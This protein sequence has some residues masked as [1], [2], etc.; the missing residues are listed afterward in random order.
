MSTKDWIEKDYY[1]V[2]GVSKDATPRRS[3][4]RTASWRETTTLIKT[5]ATPQPNCASRRSP[6]PTTCCRIRLSARST[7]RPAGCLEAAVSASRG[8]VV[9]RVTI[10]R[11]PLP[12]CRRRSRRHLRRPVQRQSHHAD[13]TVLHRR[14]PRR[15][16]DVEGEVTVDFVQAI[17]G[18]TVGMQ[19]VSD[20]A[21]E[22]CRHRRSGRDD[23]TCLPH[24]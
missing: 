23:S 19:M 4:R 18:V 20:T 8:A 12:Q 1:K 3:R 7:T 17:E 6:K 2:L 21:C 11:R 13:H 22:A 5:P 16:S 14:G 24:L 15:G 9:R 10:C